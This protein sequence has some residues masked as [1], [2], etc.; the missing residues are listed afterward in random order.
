MPEW[1]EVKRIA[2]PDQRRRLCIM[3]GPHGLFRFD[4]LRWIDAAEEDE[5]VLG[6]GYWTCDHFS[7]LYQSAGKAAHPSAL[8]MSPSVATKNSRRA[9]S[10]R[11]SR[12]LRLSRMPDALFPGFARSSGPDG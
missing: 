8:R 6:D 3:E 11:L 9:V 4:T 10:G 1:K 7:G 12:A 5:G 2:A